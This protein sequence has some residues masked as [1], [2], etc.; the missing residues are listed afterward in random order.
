[1]VSKRN[2][3]IFGCRDDTLTSNVTSN[4]SILDKFMKFTERSSFHALDTRKRNRYDLGVGISL[5]FKIFQLFLFDGSKL[6]LVK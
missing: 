6:L 3:A 4:C 5:V 2:E 1:M